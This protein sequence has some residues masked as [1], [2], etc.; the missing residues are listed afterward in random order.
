[1]H[2]PYFTERDARARRE[3]LRWLILYVLLRFTHDVGANETQLTYTLGAAEGLEQLTRPELRA[4]MIYL[5]EREL[6]HLERGDHVP[7]W[8]AKLTRFG[9]DVAEYT[10]ECDA[11]IARP[12]KDWS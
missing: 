10:I 5:D 8:H 6:I 12:L 1:M 9:T 2:Q 3:H 4:A 11:G 7:I